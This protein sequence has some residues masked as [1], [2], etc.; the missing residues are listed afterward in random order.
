MSCNITSVLKL[1]HYLLTVRQWGCVG[2][3][4]LGE[5]EGSIVVRNSIHAL[6]HGQMVDLWPLI[7]TASPTYGLVFISN[8]I[9]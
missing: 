6:S 4:K 5:V 1:M 8:F 7:S 3:Y 2:V 9:R